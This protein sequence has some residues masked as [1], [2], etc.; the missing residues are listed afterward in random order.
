MKRRFTHFN[1]TPDD[2]YEYHEDG[3][4]RHFKNGS[5][6]PLPIFFNDEWKTLDRILALKE[7]HPDE[8]IEV[9]NKDPSQEFVLNLNDFYL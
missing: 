2:Y 9:T 7:M 1:Y 6:V 4:V 3:S 5:E 8:I